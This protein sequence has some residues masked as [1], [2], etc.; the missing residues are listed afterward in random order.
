M[1]TRYATWLGA[2]L[3]YTEYFLAVCTI[4]NNWTSGKALSRA[5]EA[6][7]V[8]NL[9]PDLILI[10]QYRTLAANIEFLKASDCTMTEA[11]E[12][13]KIFSSTMTIINSSIHQETI[14]Q[15]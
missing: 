15:L 10:N 3:Y 5:K 7:T 9:V 8:S 2:T 12:L 1:I 14:I 13:L 6:T 11:Y 4:F